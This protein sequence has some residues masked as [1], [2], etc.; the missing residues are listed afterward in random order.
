MRGVIA[1]FGT[2][3]VLAALGLGAMSLVLPL[4]ETPGAHLAA[5]LSAAR[6]PAKVEPVAAAPTIV[7]VPAGSEFA[8]GQGDTAPARPAPPQAPTL[9]APSAPGVAPPEDTPDRIA[10]ADTAPAARPEAVP[11]P[12][13]QPMTEAPAQAMETPPEAE[14]PVP[15]PPPGEVTV[16][17]LG[18]VEESAS[19]AEVE[20][21]TPNEPDIAPAPDSPDQM[22]IVLGDGSQMLMPDG[23]VVSA[24]EAARQMAGE[25]TAPEQP[26][27]NETDA[28]VLGLPSEKPLELPAG[29]PDA[30]E[31]PRVFSAQ[32]PSKPMGQEVGGLSADPAIVTNRLP[33][34]GDATAEEP[35]TEPVSETVSPLQRYATDF[36]STD[37]GPLFSVVLVDVGVAAGGLDPQTLKAL[38]APVTV[39]IDPSRPDA[40]EA[41]A[42]YRRAG[43]EVAILA[44]D[45]PANAVPTD[46]EVAVEA[47]RQQIPEAIAIMDG[48]KSVFQNKRPLAQAM[49]A[50]LARE[51]LG[52]ITQQKGLNAAAQ[53]AEGAGVPHIELWREIDAARDRDTVI[54]RMLGRAA[55]EAQRD[56]Q[57]A[58]MLSGWPESVSGLQKWLPAA[59][60]VVTL[61]PASGLVLGDE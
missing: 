21:V 6:M 27:L 1:G 40:R 55:F 34:I 61:A 35:E 42:D 8:K 17:Q 31:M 52:L 39:A 19:S 5:A 4:P 24:E 60:G 3:G 23:S 9:A 46:V 16:P 38:G 22:P 58:V 10:I 56:G 45:L 2:G 47:W 57:V 33:R 26:D 51:G 32:E 18:G 37:G 13:P 29:L 20:V 28:A 15:V 36:L 59:E 30:A 7:E 43:L 41:A 53:L 48:P 54:E 14:A 49:V 12:A 44:S 11:E 50:V 25:V